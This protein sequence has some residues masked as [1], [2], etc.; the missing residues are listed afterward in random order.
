MLDALPPFQCDLN[1]IFGGLASKVPDGPP[2]YGEFVFHQQ[3]L[4]VP[5]VSLSTDRIV[6]RKAEHDYNSCYRAD[7]LWMFLS[8]P[9]CRELGLFLLA[10]GFHGPAQTTTLTLSHPES[11]IRR[12]V[13]T[14]GEVTFADLPSGLTMKPFALH[15]FVAETEGHPW[16][17]DCCSHDLPLF[18]LSNEQGS[19]ATDAQWRARDTIWIEKFSRGEFRFAELLLNAGCCWNTVREYSMEGDAGYRGVAPMSAEMRIFLPGSHAWGWDGD[20]IPM[21]DICS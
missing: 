7:G 21:P 11:D 13:V 20:E 12:I 6:I 17:H 2:G 15:Y 16:L 8:A 3:V 14:A 10:C 5:P 19:I 18:A 1:A 4:A 9:T